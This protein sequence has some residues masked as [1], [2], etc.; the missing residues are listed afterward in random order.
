MSYTWALLFG[1]IIFTWYAKGFHFINGLLHLLNNKIILLQMSV[2]QKLYFTVDM[3]WAMWFDF[4]NVFI[5][6]L[7]F[8]VH[9]SLYF[10]LFSITWTT[11]YKIKNI[12]WFLCNN[13][14]F[15]IEFLWNFRRNKIDGTIHQI[16]FFCAQVDQ[17][18]IM[19]F[20]FVE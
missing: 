1:A 14:L 17:K 10:I 13:I 6:F 9:F 5:I 3:P 7:T 4:L 2:M 11:S 15:T 12:K 16:F 19:E 18:R 20:S 8:W